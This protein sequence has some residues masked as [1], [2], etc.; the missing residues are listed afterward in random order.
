MIP[1]PNLTK[2]WM[3]NWW[4]DTNAVRNTLSCDSVEGSANLQP[5]VEQHTNPPTERIYK[6]F[7]I[8][9]L[10][11]YGDILYAL[12][13][14][15]QLKHDY[16][17]CHITWGVASIFKDILGNNPYIDSVW[18]YDV[19][20][21]EEVTSKWF[22]F[23]RL[24]ETLKRD[25]WY[26]EIYLSQ[27]FPGYPDRLRDTIRQSI[28]RAYPAKIT[29]PI[30]PVVM[31]SQ[32]E[33]DNAKLFAA[34]NMLLAKRNAILFE[35]SPG[36]GQSGVTPEFVM[37]VAE[38]LVKI[39]HTVV[40]L[41][42]KEPLYATNPAILDASKLSLREM[43]ELTKYCTFLIGSSSGVT[44][45][46]QSEQAKQLP[47]VQILSE[48]SIGSLIND[49]NYHGLPSD[50]IIELISP[51]EERVV[52]CVIACLTGNFKDAKERYSRPIVPDF[53]IVRRTA[54][55]KKAKNCLHKITG[56]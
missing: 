27:V 38:E 24:A 5:S 25:G 56:G 30:R 14:A 42:G 34:H 20:S 2:Q 46:C 7:L 35:T 23:A 29:V 11:M 10:G 54:Y 26:D 4:K 53:A 18:E 43:V 13:I 49:H 31:L 28:F 6:R 9:H 12:A 1:D 17:G 48:G 15:R 36:S 37:Q 45:I 51:T 8:G 41:S 33:S 47:T 3:Q 50:N 32:R 21:R 22:E 44:W 52:S 39:P 19:Q 55:F 16:P 40:V